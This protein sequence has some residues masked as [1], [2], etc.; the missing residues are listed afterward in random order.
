MEICPSVINIK[1]RK[2]NKNKRGGGGEVRN[3]KSIM[4][5]RKENEGRKL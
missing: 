3:I 5:R 4:F 1:Q 2:K